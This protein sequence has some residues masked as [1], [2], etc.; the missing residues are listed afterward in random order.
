MVKESKNNH[1]P[2]SVTVPCFNES[3]NIP[4]IF[5]AF[6]ELIKE[7]PTIEIIIVNNGSSD[8]SKEI[9]D[10]ELAN[11]NNSNYTILHL[12]KNHGYGS[13][14]LSGLEHSSGSVLAWTHADM[15]TNPMDILRAYYIFT[16]SD[17]ENVIVKGRR[18]NRSKIDAFFTLGMQVIA[19]ILLKEP[20]NDI[21]AQ[22]KLFSRSFYEKHIRN[23]APRDFS[24][25]LFVLYQSSKHTTVVDFPVYFKKR[26]H[27]EAKGGGT[28]KGKLKLIKRTFSYMF[29][30]KKSIDRGEQ[31]D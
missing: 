16:K 9:L 25:D 10:T 6:D 11:R 21:N 2:L 15:Q 18:R 7:I 26:V 5:S 17:S 22:P 30:L 12:E 13:G 28:F 29:L 14:I 4:L 1:V 31:D 27:G 23:K 8:N 3:G 24:L 19:S 20:L